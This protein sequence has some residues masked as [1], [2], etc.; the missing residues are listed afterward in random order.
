MEKRREREGWGCWAGVLQHINR[1]DSSTAS[2]AVSI[3]T[4]TTERNIYMG[5]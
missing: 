4:T 2:L 3:A 5:T 1:S